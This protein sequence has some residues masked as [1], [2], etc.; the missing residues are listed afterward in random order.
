MLGPA[1]MFAAPLRAQSPSRLPRIGVLRWGSR[2]DEA[3]VSLTAALAA[4]G[5]VENQT[6]IIEWRFATNRELA[7]R[8]VQEFSAMPLDLILASPTP[9]AIAMRDLTKPVPI[10]LSGVAD[11]VGVGL[12]AS[13]ARPGG[14]MTGVSTNLPGIVP[15]QL[16]LLGALRPG[17]QRVGFLGSSEDAATR[18]FVA[19]AQAGARALGLALQPVLVSGPAQF[20]AALDSLQRQGAQAVLVQPLFAVSRSDPLVELLAQHRLP[21]ITA[22]RSYAL[23]GGPLAYGFSRA[24]LS[25]RAASF[26]DRILKGASPANL[27]VEEPTAYE[28]VVNA[29]AIKAMGLAL[30]QSLLL[31]ADEVIQ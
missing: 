11:P 22:Q 7:A 23:A 14:N 19:Q 28:F 18:L 13:L 17:L 27:P 4:I 5:Y 16:Q 20:A 12:V 6:I 10:V 31:Q 2:D 29:K 3:L 8:H 26:V 15:K 25:R 21:S 24:D 30:P 9:A 1:W